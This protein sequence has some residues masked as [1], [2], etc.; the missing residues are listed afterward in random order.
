MFS[1]FSSAAAAAFLLSVLAVLFFALLFA[2]SFFALLFLRFSL[3]FTAFLLALGG[4]LP[5]RTEM[6]V[7][8]INDHDDYSQSMDGQ[9]NSQDQIS[10]EKH[11]LEN[12]NTV[13]K[14]TILN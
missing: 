5:F 11:D 2:L 7:G 13:E 6:E 12:S 9:G 14:A 8:E 4:L 3:F 1:A 10:S